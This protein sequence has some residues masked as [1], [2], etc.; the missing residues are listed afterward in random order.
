MPGMP[1]I[2]ILPVRHVVELVGQPLADLIDRPPWDF[3]HVEHIR[4]EYPP[5][6]RDQVIDADI[7]ACDPL[8]HFEL[9][10]LDVEAEEIAAFPRDNDNGAIVG[11]LDE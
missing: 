7:A 6:L 5:R 10:E 1:E 11:G 2:P 4:I 9:G 3:F 8:A